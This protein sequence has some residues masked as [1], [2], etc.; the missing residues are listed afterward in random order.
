MC[1]QTRKCAVSVEKGCG[2]L[3]QAVAWLEVGRGLIGSQVASMQTPL[4]DLSERHRDFARDLRE[5]SLRLPQLGT[6]ESQPH[7]STSNHGT[8][9]RDGLTSLDGYVEFSADQCRRVAINYEGFIRPKKLAGFIS[10][11]VFTRL[12]GTIVFINV[13][14]ASCDALVLFSYRHCLGC[15]ATGSDPGTRGKVAIFVGT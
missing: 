13:S 1:R 2:D 9:K 8:H 15:E 12:N 14:V 6:T 7:T 5:I 3:S 4:D 11:P 10:S